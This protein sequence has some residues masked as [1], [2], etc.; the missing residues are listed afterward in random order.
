MRK[1]KNICIIGYKCTGKS[2]VAN[3]LGDKLGWKVYHINKIIQRQENKSLKELTDNNTDWRYFRKVEYELLC[4]LLQEEDVII[5]C[6][7]GI[8]VNEVNMN[9]EF[10]LL[11]NSSNLSAKSCN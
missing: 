5:D 6:N 10:R 2:Y 8:P 11:N 3:L 9:E 4:S 7:E 1:Y